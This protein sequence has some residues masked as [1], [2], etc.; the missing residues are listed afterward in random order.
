MNL[1]IVPCVV[2]PQM[3]RDC[4]TSLLAQDIETNVLAINNGSTD[5][6]PQMVPPQPEQRMEHLD[7]MGV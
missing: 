2:G 7:H 5:G 6:T 1:V 3:T 4:L